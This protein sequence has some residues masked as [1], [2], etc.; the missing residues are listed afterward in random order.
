LQTHKLRFSKARRPSCPQGD[1]SAFSQGGL[2]LQ[3]P[4]ADHCCV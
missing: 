2:T 1:N 3:L 4:F